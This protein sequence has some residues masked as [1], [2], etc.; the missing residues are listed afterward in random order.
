VDTA[1]IVEICRNAGHLGD[2]R[3]M[4]EILGVTILVFLIIFSSL[5]VPKAS[6]DLCQVKKRQRVHYMGNIKPTLWRAHRVRQPPPL[7]VHQEARS[8]CQHQ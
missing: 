7:L 6:C 2:I 4:W 1:A 8:M 5:F 3:I